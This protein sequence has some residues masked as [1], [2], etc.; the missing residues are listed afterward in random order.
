MIKNEINKYPFSII[1][2]IELDDNELNIEQL[3]Q[4]LKLMKVQNIKWKYNAKIIGVD[5]SH[6]LTVKEGAQDN[7]RE[8][9]VMTPLEIESIPWSFPQLDSRSIINLARDLLPY[10]EG[11][12]YI[13][14]AP[15][16]RIDYIDNNWIYMR[17][18]EVSN[19]L[20]KIQEEKLPNKLKYNYGSVKISTNFYNPVFHYLNPFYIETSR[21]PISSSSFISIQADKAIAIIS[22][23][24]FEFSFNK[25][26]IE[27]TG[28]DIYTAQLNKWNEERL[29]RINWNLNNN[30]I[31]TDFKPKYNVSLYR[32]EPSS[33]IP[34][35][36]KYDNNNKI[37]YL[38]VINMSDEDLI[39]TVFFTA[40]IESVMADGENIEPEFDRIEFP[41][42]KWRIKNLE[43]K[44]RKLLDAYIKRKIIA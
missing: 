21:K 24:P 41:I 13:N 18:G 34:I 4:I 6:V 22:S 37:I 33:I 10:E 7:D 5:G 40:R 44:I 32:I 35:Y 17:A 11:E 16:D 30:I 12:G 2:N 31:K 1:Q 25:G 9:L 23:S 27:V 8:Y 29:F 42:R 36:I 38:S 14:P 3:P 26:D 15:W 28:K 20:R 19:T 43:I 39:S